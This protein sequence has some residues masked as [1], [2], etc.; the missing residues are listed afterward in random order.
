MSES[1]KGPARP[2]TVHATMKRKI[3]AG[4]PRR[5]DVGRGREVG[6]GSD[7]EGLDQTGAHSR[8]GSRRVEDR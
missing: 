8:K 1:K 3:R 7:G 4:L 6:G 5:R 2:P